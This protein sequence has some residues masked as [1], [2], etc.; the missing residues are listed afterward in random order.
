MRFREGITSFLPE[1]AGLMALAQI[2]QSE[3]RFAA[4]LRVALS[5]G[6][7]RAKPTDVGDGYGME[8]R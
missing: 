3:G 1:L 4:S 2:L 5:K 8:A 7:L 6:G